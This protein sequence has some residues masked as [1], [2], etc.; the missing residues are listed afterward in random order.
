VSAEISPPEGYSWDDVKVTLP[1]PKGVRSGEMNRKPK[2]VKGL[3][4]WSLG[5]V[6]RGGRCPLVAKFALT[7][8]LDTY[9]DEPPPFKVTYTAVAQPVLDWSIV[10]PDQVRNG[11]TFSADVTL[12]NRGAAPTE[13]VAV[14]VT[15]EGDP[16][17]EQI[18]S[19]GP[20]RPGETKTLSVPL[21]APDTTGTFCWQVGV[22]A[23]EMTDADEFSVTTFM[24]VQ[25][26]VT[27]P[28]SIGLDAAAPFRVTVVNPTSQPQKALRISLIVP[29]Q[30]VYDSSDGNYH[31]DTGLVEWTISE[32]AGREERTITAWLRGHLPG[33]V[34]VVAT[35]RTS[36]DMLSATATTVCELP[37]E[38]QPTSLAAALAEMDTAMDARRD[39]AKTSA[40]GAGERH[41]LF[42]MG[43]TIYAAPIGQLREVIR[44]PT[45]TPVPDTPDLLLGLANVRGDV[46][47]IVSFAHLLG[48][49]TSETS[50]RS[51]LI[52]QSA[53][54]R[55]EVG[56]QVDEV[57][58]IRRITSSPWTGDELEESPIA[59]FLV[60]LGEHCERLVPILDLERVLTS[61]R[62][63]LTEAA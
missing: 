47:S 10:A 7:P 23:G 62:T 37:R 52:A 25:I 39:E 31:P 5:H 59:E 4:T 58:G 50:K 14:R 29:P 51:I 49:D 63:S 35:I 16:T 2:V 60:G 33:E 53:E 24:P 56:F 12:V 61:P 28:T 32:F 21:I 44:P 41:V 15:R 30:L 1:I 43:D 40:V 54:G 57:I 20:I 11:G 42:R 3:I 6:A 34:R 9:I 18:H 17:A 55:T 19:T 36:L 48:L 8:A 26:A 27:A 45:I 38:H 46:V 13:P 22:T